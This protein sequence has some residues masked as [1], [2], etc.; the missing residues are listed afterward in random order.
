MNII[1]AGAGEVGSHLALMLSQENQD[2]VLIDPFPSRLERIKYHAEV[3][4]KVGNPISFRDL[5]EAGVRHADLFISV[6]P[7]EATNIVACSI[8]SKLGAKK[9]LARVENSEYLQYEEARHFSR[10][11]VNTMIS[12]ELL[13][14]KEIVSSI[15]T[16]WARQYFELFDGSIALVGVKVREGAPL[17][18]MFLNELQNREE[19]K[20]YHIVAI[21]RDFETIIPNGSTQVLHGDVVFFTVLKAKLDDIRQLAGKRN[22]QV[23]K[24]VI[25]GG[26][27]VAL[28]AIE[29]LPPHIHVSLVE[30]DK[31]EASL[32][33]SMSPANVEVF[34]GDGRDPDLLKEVGLNYAEAFIALTGNSETNVLACLSA[35]R[36]GVFK[37]IAKEENIDYITLA[38]R[39]DI[40]TLINQ[41]LLA[42]GYIYR[43]FLGED[44]NT[45]KSLTIAN[46]DVADLIVKRNSFVTQR[47][48]K[49]LL[50]P[51]GI[52]LGGMV[53]NGVAQMID[54][55]TTL[56]PFD[57]VVVFCMNHPINKLNELFG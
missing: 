4:T 30:R 43:L 42:A 51:K 26:S 39:L 27:R 9:T 47:P 19:K 49:D 53:R 11:G 57:H 40:G 50:L 35:K 29:L 36:F 52:T 7:E 22:V 44:S 13:A 1:I 34:N 48:V 45:V 12:P 8:A 41:K 32:I 38:D 2:I 15:K 5:I 31:E 54:G 16:P 28:R 24:I 37:T 33:S 46:A 3:L 25:M 21:K 14:A 10:L 20:S 17:E 56:Q 18:G 55:N 6:M 23:K